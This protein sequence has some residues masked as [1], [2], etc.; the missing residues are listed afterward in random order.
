MGLME[1]KLIPHENEGTLFDII[2]RSVSKIIPSHIIIAEKKCW[3][4]DSELYV[5]EEV[6]VFTLTDQ[7]KTS[8]QY[9]FK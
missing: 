7:Q 9:H 8:I 4:C 2:C 3:D 6:S 1:I 5:Q